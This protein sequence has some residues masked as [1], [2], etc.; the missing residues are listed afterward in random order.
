[1]ATSRITKWDNTDVYTNNAEIHTRMFDFVDPHAKKKITKFFITFTGDTNQS[2]IALT[3]YF[4]FH[5]ND[6][7][8]LFGSGT[9]SGTGGRRL[10]IT[11]V[12]NST[13]SFQME[14]A[15]T[16]NGGEVLAVRIKNVYTIQFKITFS[17]TEK[18]EINDYG[19][20]FRNVRS[21]NISEPSV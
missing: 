11:P 16:S 20:E 17:A 8:K 5:N 12:Y 13:S 1:M 4:R 14:Q 9:T 6:A 2:L 18:V 7:W 19:I 15:P 3:L 10:E 21:T